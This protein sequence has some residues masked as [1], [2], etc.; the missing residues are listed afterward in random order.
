[1]AGARRDNPVALM[2]ARGA[3]LPTSSCSAAVAGG[4][5]VMAIPWKMQFDNTQLDVGQVVAHDPT[6]SVPS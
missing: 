1:M 5:A 4:I 2:P 6:P 3:F